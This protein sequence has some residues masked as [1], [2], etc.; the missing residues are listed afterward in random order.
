[1]QEL[2]IDKHDINRNKTEEIEGKIT[3]EVIC[4]N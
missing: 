3:N 2:R 1:M 4:G